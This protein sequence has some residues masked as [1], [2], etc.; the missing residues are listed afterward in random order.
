DGRRHVDA[1]RRVDR[2]HRV[3]CRHP[4]RRQWR[5]SDR[6]FPAARPKR[7]A[8]VFSGALSARE[9]LLEER[10]EVGDRLEE[11]RRRLPEEPDRRTSLWRLH[12][13]F[14]G[15]VMPSNAKTHLPPEAAARD[16]RR[17][18]IP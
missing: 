1:R 18:E 17:Q 12:R 4:G 16:E 13:T 7:R 5:R 6:T 15:S 10:R 3:D 9:R 2:W 14:T 8:A 11:Q